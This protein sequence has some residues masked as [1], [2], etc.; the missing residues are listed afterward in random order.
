MMRRFAAARRGGVM[1]IIIMVV[2]IGACVYFFINRD[3]TPSPKEVA[4]Q[5]QQEPEA[6]LKFYLSTAYHF[7]H[8]EPGGTFDHVKLTVTKD[9]WD[10]YQAHYQELMADPFNVTSGIDP[11]TAHAVSKRVSMMNLFN[12][13]PNRADVEITS[14]T[15]SSSVATYVVRYKVGIDNDSFAEREVRMVKEDD[16]WKMSDWAG[17]RTLY[18][19]P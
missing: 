4:S 14:P 15:L 5:N 10:W 9:D 12:A 3:T 6:A 16:L 11:T 1:N 13:G 17:A 18:R 7:M 8:D 2:L 19:I